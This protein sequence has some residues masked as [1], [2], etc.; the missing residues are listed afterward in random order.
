MD[1][2]LMCVPIGQTIGHAGE[3]DFTA[4]AD[5]RIT[6]GPG[7]VYGGVQILKT[8]GLQNIPEQAFSLNLLWNQMHDR[9]RLFALE[10]PGRW[11]DVGR[12]EGIALAEGM[13]ADV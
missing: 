10:Y 13:L 6:R 5:G 11:C 7:L 3:G 2:L 12:P 8:D 4:D 1:A 9:N